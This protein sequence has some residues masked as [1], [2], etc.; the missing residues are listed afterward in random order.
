VRFTSLHGALLAVALLA[1]CGGD[2][3]DDDAGVGGN[4]EGCGD[5]GSH[6]VE[7]AAYSC[8][9]E[10]GYSW[11]SDALDDFN[12]CATDEPDHDT[13]GD[14]PGPSE[15][16]DADSLER[17]V[18]V[19]D[20]EDPEHPG[21][22]TIW[23]CNGERWVLAA[24]Y[25]TFV[26]LAES[27]PFAYGCAPGLDQPQFLCGFGP[28]TSCDPAQYPSVC[29]KEDIIDACVWGRRTVD[30]CARLC[31]E[32]D[33]FGAG[34]TGGACAQPDPDAPATCVCD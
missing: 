15:T 22:S 2:D 26:C 16:C 10:P 14:D 12:C 11:C 18:C 34:H 33:A 20:P 24:N 1:G 5:P 13:G 23:A 29:T 3:D 30:R 4:R 6:S 27:F 8:Q 31:A 25:S 28:G 32:L 21:G 19:S 17:L 7:L 9:C